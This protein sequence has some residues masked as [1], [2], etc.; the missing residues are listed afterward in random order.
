MQQV[1]SVSALGGRLAQPSMASSCT[2]SFP[3]A[4]GLVGVA[5]AAAVS[6]DN[7]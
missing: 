6:V 3:G 2:V 7:H 1:C 4:P 5:S